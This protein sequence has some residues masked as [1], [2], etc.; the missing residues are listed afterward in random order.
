MCVHWLDACLLPPIPP[1]RVQWGLLATAQYTT[2]F[3]TKNLA[4]HG[5]EYDSNT[6]SYP[7]LA[8]HGTEYESSYKQ[9]AFTRDD[10]GHWQRQALEIVEARIPTK[11]AHYFVPY[12]N[13]VDT[14]IGRAQL[15]DIDHITT[16][17]KCGNMVRTYVAPWI[18]K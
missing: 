8:C 5:T 3:L 6:N 1:A 11:P 17:S 4:C 2:L 10:L 15:H 14:H 13:F 7:S 18:R 12:I 9:P 16:S